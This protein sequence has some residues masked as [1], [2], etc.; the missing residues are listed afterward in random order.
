M[1]TLPQYIT[2]M[3]NTAWDLCKRFGV[4]VQYE[5]KSDRAELLSVLGVQA[6]LIDLLVKKG[7][8][9]DAELLAAINA[10]R[11]SPWQPVQ[12]T[13]RPVEWGRPPS[14]SAGTWARSSPVCAGRGTS[15]WCAGSAP[16]P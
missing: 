3:R 9:T 6:I 8:V 2:V 7:V 12:L 15:T 5:A 14:S 16:T 4:D 1:A 10:V 13:E 11:N